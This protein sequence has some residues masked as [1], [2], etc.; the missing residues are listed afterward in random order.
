MCLKYQTY[1][2]AKITEIP[3]KPPPHPRLT[4]C[5]DFRDIKPQK[6]LKKT[7]FCDSKF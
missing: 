3:E 4:N 6:V 1:F 5:L 7:Q 2:I